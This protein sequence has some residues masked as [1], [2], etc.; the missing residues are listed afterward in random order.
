MKE[1]NRK[2][3]GEQ[4]REVREEQGW[5]Q[6]QLAAF[7]G[8]KEQTIAKIEEGLYNVSLDLIGTVCE[9]LGVN[10]VLMED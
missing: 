7:V 4:V 3:L 10:I 5:T 6:E 2:K 1:E 8:V 9:A